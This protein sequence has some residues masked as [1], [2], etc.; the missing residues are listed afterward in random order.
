MLW[1][2]RSSNTES[3]SEENRT[4]PIITLKGPRRRYLC[5]REEESAREIERRP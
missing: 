3:D 2:T 4:V 5:S 1:V